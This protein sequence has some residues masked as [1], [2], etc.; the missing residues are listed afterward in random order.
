M[1]PVKERLQAAFE[2][3]AELALLD[4]GSVKCRAAQVSILAGV[5]VVDFY[6][7]HFSPS[8]QKSYRAEKAAVRRMETARNEDDNEMSSLVE[9]ALIPSLNGIARELTNQIL[10]KTDARGLFRIIDQVSVGLQFASV[11]HEDE[12]DW[13][14]PPI[15]AKDGSVS[16][17]GKIL[18]SADEVSRIGS[19]RVLEKKDALLIASWLGHALHDVPRLLPDWDAVPDNSEVATLN[20]SECPRAPAGADKHEFVM[21]RLFTRWSN[22]AGEPHTAPPN[23][24]S[25]AI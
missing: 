17:A 13:T 23:A 20:Y 21:S 10:T 22:K 9:R 7:Q 2:R 11:G 1:K 15:V 8:G 25:P 4:D 6:N 14:K 24:P 19:G 5:A 16:V 3:V 18:F 12:Y